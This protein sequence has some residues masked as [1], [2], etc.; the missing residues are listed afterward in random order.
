MRHPARHLPR[1]EVARPALTTPPPPVALQPRGTVE[2]EPHVDARPTNGALCVAWAS[3][4]WINE[5]RTIS[6]FPANL[7]LNSKIQTSVCIVKLLIAKIRP[8]EA[9]FEKRKGTRN[10]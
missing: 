7:E 2:V 4:V 8:I 6:N 1:P 9:M 10:L 3:W 5:L